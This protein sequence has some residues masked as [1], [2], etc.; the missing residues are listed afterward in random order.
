MGSS[1]RDLRTGAHLCPFCR[2]SQWR[3]MSVNRVTPSISFRIS[4]FRS[5]FDVS[6][7]F[8]TS[9]LRDGISKVKDGD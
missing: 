9:D 3:A 7:M 6:N 1:R 4:P 2:R 8:A 5:I